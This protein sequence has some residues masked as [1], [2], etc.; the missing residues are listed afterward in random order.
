MIQRGSKKLSLYKG[1]KR[2]AKLRRAFPVAT[3]LPSYPTPLGRFTVG[4]KQAHPWWCPP[5]SDWAEGLE[6]VPP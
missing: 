2:G 3:G 4:T 6:P 5:N 1:A